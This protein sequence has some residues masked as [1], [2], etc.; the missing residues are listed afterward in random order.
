[1][2]M[3]CTQ[4]NVGLICLAGTLREVTQPVSTAPP[5][6]QWQGC[7][8]PHHEHKELLFDQP[9]MS[10]PADLIL[11]AYGYAYFIQMHFRVCLKKALLPV[12]A[13][14]PFPGQLNIS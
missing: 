13:M 3:H 2:K 6:F 5:L 4:S 10:H 14:V 9:A 12:I 7:R 8:H 1:M 11:V